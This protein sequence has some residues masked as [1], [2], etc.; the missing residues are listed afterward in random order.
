MTISAIVRV[1]GL[2]LLGGVTCALVFTSIAHAPSKIT[3]KVSVMSPSPTPSLALPLDTLSGQAIYVLDTT[4]GRI[5][6]AKNAQYRFS[7]AS[8]TKLMSILVASSYF[9]FTDTIVASH[10][11]TEGVMIGLK[12][13]DRLTFEHALYAMLL[14]S[15]NDVAQA[16]A[17]NYPGGKPAFIQAMNDK[18][19]ELHLE[20]TT[21]ADPAGLEDDSGYTTAQELTHIASVFV[22]NKAIAHIASIQSATIPVDG[23]GMVK[24][25]NTN[26]LLGYKGINGL[27]T[28]TTEGAKEVLVTSLPLRGHTIIITVMKSDDRFADTKTIVDYLEKHYLN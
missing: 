14:P 5:L 8:T 1:S 22:E 4:N 7:A 9:K 19:R 11:G 18:A 20:R 21:F 28:G 27:K 25:V 17:D 13:G 2:V 16:V 3:K 12:P 24:L 26:L 10:A 6:G 15:A 23:I